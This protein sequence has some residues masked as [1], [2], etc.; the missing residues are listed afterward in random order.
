MATR[1][2]KIANI[3]KRIKEIEAQ[4]QDIGKA[5]AKKVAAKIP[6]K[7]S[8]GP[9]L[10]PI[11]REPILKLKPPRRPVITQ[12]TYAGPS[13]VDYLKSIGQPS[14]FTSRKK[15]AAQTGIT[16]YT[17]TAAQNTQLLNLLR[18]G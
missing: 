10:T 17:G 3:A 4:F 16:N 9:I 8:P 11:I 14:S 7:P 12:T 2:E 15:L 6:P 1:K 13:I 5:V 18:K